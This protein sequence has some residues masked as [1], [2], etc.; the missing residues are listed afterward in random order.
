[1]KSKIKWN[2]FTKKMGKVCVEIK[3]KNGA[4][5]FILKKLDEKWMLKVIIER[6]SFDLSHYAAKYM[7]LACTST[8][9]DKFVWFA[10]PRQIKLKLETEKEL[11]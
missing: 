5:E 2:E 7:I 8:I 9:P 4:W 11:K 3:L 1:M 10:A 6:F